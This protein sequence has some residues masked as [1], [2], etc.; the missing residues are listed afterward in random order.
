MIISELLSRFIGG[1]GQLVKGLYYIPE[2]AIHFKP[3]PDSWSISEIIVHLADAE[4]FGL[5][6]AKKIIAECGDPVTVY[7]Q[8]IWADHLFYDQMNY[9]DALDLIR[10][11]RKN[12]Y[13][14]LKLLS[15][16]TWQNYVYHPETGKITLFQWVLS[17][18]DHIDV[19]V[20]QIH[21]NYEDWK[22][23]NVETIHPHLL[24]QAISYFKNVKM[25]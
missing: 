4:T 18:I 14:V 23:I 21:Q 16:E 25:F 17:N 24:D 11:L 3:T 22:R 15:P 19:H 2:Q 7:N 6:R 8:Q 9:L 5:V 12:L 1:H 20:A 10:L 13:D